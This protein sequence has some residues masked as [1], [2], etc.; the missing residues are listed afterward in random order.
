MRLRIDT[1]IIIAILFCS[2]L[3]S[4]VIG[5]STI[6]RS[7]EIIKNEVKDKILQ[8][9]LSRGNEFTIQ[10][11]RIENTVI[12]L[13][14]LVLDSIDFSKVKNDQYM[15]E[16]LDT[17]SSIVKSL[18][19]YNKGIVGLYVNFDPLFTSGTTAYDIGYTYDEM[20]K[21]S[22]VVLNGYTLDEFFETNEDLSWYYEP[23]KAKKGVWSMPYVDSVSGVNMISYTMPFYYKEALV[24]VVGIDLSFESLRSLILD[25]KVYESGYA[26]LLNND[27]TYMVDA[28]FTSED[29]LGTISNGRY[30]SLTEEI[31]TKRESVNELMFEGEKSIIGYNTL[32]SGL[33]IGVI[34]PSSE[35]LTSIQQLSFN[36]IIVIILGIIVS[37]VVG[38]LLSRNITSP[39]NH[40]LKQLKIISQGDFTRDLTQQFLHR[41]DEVGEIVLM[42]SQLQISLKLLLE[43]VKSEAL[44]I[45]DDINTVTKNVFALNKNIDAVSENTDSLAATM[46][47]AAASTE[48]METQTYEIEH[49]IESISKSAQGGAEQALLINKRATD[50]KEAVYLA[51]N[52]AKNMIESTQQTLKDAINNAKIVEQIKILTQSIMQITAQTNLLALNAAIEAARAG[53]AGKGFSVVADEIRKLA[54][55]SKNTALEIQE[56]TQKVTESVQDLSTSSDNL[57]RFVDND[58]RNDYEVMMNVASQYSEDAKFVD[59]IVTELSATSEEL[60]ASIQEVLRSINE[61]TLASSSGAQGTSDIARNVELIALESNENLKRVEHTK[62]SSN[63]LIA[64]VSKFKV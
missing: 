33:I 60:L 15:T 47:Q 11:S 19:D 29:N 6:L 62:T 38:I 54:E 14:G 20:T 52:K 25:T 3:L 53:E 4:V 27:F 5:T 42:V 51:Q 13:S 58:V 64:V 59:D 55:Q 34:V 36:I 32:P 40:A 9:A 16:Y 61:V 43:S 30:V 10:T 26:F 21:T 49:A 23:V 50:T 44:N 8:I 39:L 2:I 56:I 41:K 63:V 17:M 22:E 7:T 24:G 18:G 28:K 57:L 48:T 37:L 45:E 46:E 1:K 35:V 31:S 12:E